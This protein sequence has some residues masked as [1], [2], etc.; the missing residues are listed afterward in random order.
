MEWLEAD[1]TLELLLAPVNR[2]PL[3]VLEPEFTMILLVL[4]VPLLPIAVTAELLI[5]VLGT[6]PGT[7]TVAV[8]AAVLTEELLSLPA[9]L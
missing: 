8:L 1:E 2:T 4:L 6:V 3:L 7:L 5:T 9:E